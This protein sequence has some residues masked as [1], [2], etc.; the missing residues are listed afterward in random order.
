MQTEHLIRV[1]TFCVSHNIDFAFISSL[2]EMGLIEIVNDEEVKFIHDEEL[3]KLEQIVRLHYDL[4]INPE[5]IE[6]I[7]HLL[8]RIEESEKEINSLRNR[9]GMYEVR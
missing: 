3:R 9:L 8:H 7:F 1:E 2:Q 6:A 5:G 4:A